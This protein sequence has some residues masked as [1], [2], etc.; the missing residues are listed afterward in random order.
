MK[1]VMHMFIFDNRRMVARHTDFTL[2][3]LL[4][5][6]AI[7]AILTAMLLPALKGAKEK[8]KQISC[9]NNLKNIGFALFDY[10]DSNNDYIP[11]TCWDTPGSPPH[12]YITLGAYFNYDYDTNWNGMKVFFCPSN[13]PDSAYWLGYAKTDDVS[14]F[15]SSG[16]AKLSSLRSPSMTLSFADVG[17][18]ST[19]TGNTWT[20]DVYI[21]GTSGNTGYRHSGGADILFFDGHTEWH[22]ARIPDGTF[23]P[24]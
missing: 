8:A 21:L 24:P 2:I 17:D 23:T 15:F 4:V 13:P 18:N 16:L 20:H 5:V 3:E 6:I 10:C 12:W 7:I 14:C 9:F 19:G 22:R 11:P 1:M